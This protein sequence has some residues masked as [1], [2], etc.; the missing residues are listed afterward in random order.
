[1]SR[2]ADY[3]IKGFLYQFNKTLVEILGASE[4]DIINVEGIVEDVEIV[5]PD[6]ITAIQ[7]KYHEASESFAVSSIF[8][9]LLQM[10]YHFHQNTEADIQYILFAHFPSVEKGKEPPIGNNEFQSALNSNNKEF[11]KY[12][13]ALSGKIDLDSFGS[14]FRME[15]GEKYDDIVQSVHS[16]LIDNGIPEGEIETLAYPNAINMV[17]NISIKHDPTERSISKR[18]FLDELRSIRTTAISRWTLTLR[19]RKQLLDA[20]RKQLKADL[21]KNSRSRYFV[22][23]SSSLDDFSEEIVLFINDY[24]EKYHFKP[25][26]I[27]TPLFCLRA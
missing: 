25:A 8:K 5:T 12:T 3:T 14:C 10:M 2:T 27:N 15:F 23:N 22:I 17:A 4:D 6:K 18:Q 7:C 20:R 16:S 9:P 26:H 13:E 24:L 1:M 19:T 11:K 21:D